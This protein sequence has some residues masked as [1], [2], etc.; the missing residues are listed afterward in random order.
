MG[1]AE[2]IAR[3]VDGPVTRASLTADLAALDLAGATVLVHASLSAL[4]WVC[5]GPV[6][7]CEALR[8]A[9]GRDG[10]L[11]V[12]THTGLSDP[13]HWEHPPVPAAWVPTVR[14]ALPPFDRAL[15]PTR[16]M[17]AIPEV[18]RTHPEALRSPHPEVSF[19]ALGP[20]AEELC[21]AHPLG[22]RL[23]ERSPLARLHDAEALV[24]LLG[25]DHAVNTSLHLAEYRSRVVARHRHHRLVPPCADGGNEA[26]EGA[27][28][29][30][31]DVV[32]DETD[33][34]D[35]GS[36]YEAAHPDRLRLGRAGYGTARVLEQRHLVGYAVGWLDRNR[37]P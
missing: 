14:A 22:D 26:P 9:I 24:L 12:P 27:W 6:A 5:G 16:G 30:V 15:T 18:V 29:E 20:R 3:S 28:I 17:G 34:A 11:V 33:F 13:A 35:L 2:A 7:V 10:T 37:R 31:S 8:A 1:E 19:T 32:L 23:G 36:D 4:G 21:G 25:V